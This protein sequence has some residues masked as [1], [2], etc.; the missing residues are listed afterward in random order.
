MNGVIDHLYTPQPVAVAKRSES[1]TVFDRSEAVIM[2]SNPVL[3]MDVY[4][5]SGVSVFVMSCI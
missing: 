5:V 2:A 4:C 1:W 3:G